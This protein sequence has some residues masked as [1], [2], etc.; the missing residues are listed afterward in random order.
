MDFTAPD[1]EAE[2]RRLRQQVEELKSQ[3]PVYSRVQASPGA[4]VCRSSPVGAGTSFKAKSLWRGS[5]F[6]RAST[7]RV[8]LHETFGTEGCVGDR[9]PISGGGVEPTL[10]HRGSETA[11][12]VRGCVYGGEFGEVRVLQGRSRRE[13][14]RYGMRA[15]RIGE[16]SHPGPRSGARGS[17]QRRRSRSRGA[18]ED[19]L[20]AL[21]FDLTQ[22]DSDS[23]GQGNGRQSAAGQVQSVDG[24]C[25]FQCP[26]GTCKNA[27]GQWAHKE[28]CHLTTSL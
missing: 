9:G 24:S 6:Q 1:W 11:D 23:N 4:I 28:M 20:D 10:G 12:T 16:A 21:Q 25:M 19:V 17:L 8:A 14:A 2:A 26:S 5:A 7:R 22:F 3:G 13:E 18:P 27:R 15:S